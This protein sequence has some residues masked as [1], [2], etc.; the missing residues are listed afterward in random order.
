MTHITIKKVW[1]D[2]NNQDGKRPDSLTVKLS[3]GTY[4]TLNDLNVWSYTVVNLPKYANGNEIVYTWTE[5]VMPEGYTLTNNELHGTITVLTNTHTP[6]TTDLTVKK[7][8]ND[9]NDQDGKRPDELKATLSN[10]TEVTLNEAN[11]WSATVTDLPVYE[12]GKKIVYTWTES[13][14][15]EGYALTNTEVDGTVTTL[16]NSYL[17]ATTTVT[18][19]KVWDDANNQDGKRPTRLVVTLSNGMDVVLNADNNWSTTITDLPAYANGELIEYT[20]TE[21]EL[22]E[23]YVLTSTEVNGTITTLTNSYTPETTSVTVIKQWD[24][25]N[26]QDGKR[27]SELKVTL[28]NNVE[29]TLNAAN[30]WT[31]T[32]DNLPVYAN[33]EKIEYT[34]SEALPEGYTLTD[35]TVNGTI[36]TLTN[37]YTPETVEVAGTK[38]WED[39]NDQDGM[40]PEAIVV[41]LMA[42]GSEIDYHVVK[43][44]DDWKYAFTDLPKYQNGVEVVYTIKETEVEGYTVE[45]DGYNLV[46]T[47]IPAVKDITVTKQWDDADNQDGYR[48]S[49]ITVE[50]LANNRLVFTVDIT[51]ENEWKHTFENLPVYENGE[52]IVYTVNELAV[53]KY[54]ATI[55]GYNITNIHVPETVT[56]NVTK[57]WDDAENLHKTRPESIT[58]VLFANGEQ[59]EQ[60]VTLN[61]DNN[62]DGSFVDLPKYQDG[63][64]I[65]YTADEIEVPNEYTKDS[66]VQDGYNVVITN[67]M[68]PRVPETSDTST[69]RLWNLLLVLSSLGAVVSIKKRKEEE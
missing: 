51:E 38:T 26:N 9:A 1:D 23:G 49:Q 8:W 28:S 32:V 41:K 46:N 3:D 29:V 64:E 43:A 18:V 68:K 50:L 59:T 14:L 56:L 25:A 19:N 62:W 12:N 11:E 6:E 17:P 65:Q 20:W 37:S 58:V 48:L 24:D 34:W 35:T 52:E 53:D 45:V 13:E 66:V 4:V 31:A 67:K 7:V 39:A 44:T 69:T 42:N 27:P 63:V 30:N 57:V 55:D 16:T 5:V 40:R 61:S 22:P 33:G 2:N 36:T 60:V 10:G 15:P 54:S 47:H 21:K